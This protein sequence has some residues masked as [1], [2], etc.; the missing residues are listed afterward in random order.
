MGLMGVE[1]NDS[2]TMLRCAAN[3][4]A[5]VASRRQYHDAWTVEDGES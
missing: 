5:R 1:N 4:H 3:G 2:I